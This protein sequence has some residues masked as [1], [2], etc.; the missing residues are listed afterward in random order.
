MCKIIAV[1]MKERFPAI[2]L[3]VYDLS[4]LRS[5]RFIGCSK[6]KPDGTIDKTPF[7]T[8]ATPD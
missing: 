6:I 5:L 4:E 8:T 2:D 7:Q 3:A 1:E